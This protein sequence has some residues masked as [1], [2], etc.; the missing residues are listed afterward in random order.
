MDNSFNGL[1]SLDSSLYSQ[2]RQQIQ[3]NPSEGNRMDAK[4]KTYALEELQERVMA[5]ETRAAYQEK[6]IDA[7]DSVVQEQYQLID[8]ITE[9]LVTLQ[10]RVT[11]MSVGEQEINLL[12]EKPP[13][14]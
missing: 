11:D 7:L 3:T 8:R 13:H 2:M 1:Q 14:Y 6:T 9:Q 5:L 10:S 12:D 4:D